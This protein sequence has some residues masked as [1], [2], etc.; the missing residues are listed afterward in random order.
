MLP[1]VS[2][3]FFR[4]VN[5]RKL[6]IQHIRAVSKSCKL[7]STVFY[8]QSVPMVQLRD[9]SPGSVFK[10][11]VELHAKANPFVLIGCLL[12]QRGCNQKMMQATFRYDVQFH[13]IC[14][15][16][17]F[18]KLYKFQGICKA[19]LYIVFN[20]SEHTPDNLMV[21]IQFHRHEYL[22]LYIS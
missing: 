13:L 9:E 8:V 6:A 1:I 20:I 7:F 16:S 17:L 4:T 2:S 12:I 22:I 5:C 11:V 18:C 10:V 3:C 14:V 21:Q 19:V 15:T